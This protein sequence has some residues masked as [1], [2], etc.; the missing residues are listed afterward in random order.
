MLDYLANEPQRVLALGDNGVSPETIEAAVRS[1]SIQVASVDRVFWGSRDSDVF[2]KQLLHIE[3]KGAEAE[4]Y[5][6]ELDELVGNATLIVNHISPL[7]RSVIERAPHLKA[8]LSCRGGYENIDL[9]AATERNIPVVNVIRNAIPVAEYTLGLIIAVTRNIALSH[10]KLVA[11][12]WCK[13]YPNSTF[14][15]TLTNLTVGLVG[16]GNIGIELAVRLKALGIPVIAYD[17]FVDIQRLKSYG[18]ADVELTGSPEELFERADVVS[19][20]LRLTPETEHTIDRRFFSRMKPTSY[21]IN[22]A[23]GGLVNQADLL[24]AL[25]RHAIAGAALDV[26]DEEPLPLDSGFQELDNV[27]ITSHIAG[28]TV[29]ATTH[30]PYLLLREVDKILKMGV[31]DRIVNAV[32]LGLR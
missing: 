17:A 19:L 22:T 15:S 29:D 11:G 6:S 26:F 10:N 28:T 27:I 2:A 14:T 20:H 1:S 4:P 16:I 21:F 31:T 7:P 9:E 13:E 32:D 18:L 5:A 24:D 12:T 23:R 30:A 25:Q 8:I 3:R